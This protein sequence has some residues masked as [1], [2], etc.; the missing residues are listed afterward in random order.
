MGRVFCWWGFFLCGK[1]WDT[2]F[3]HCPRLW[4]R[5][6]QRVAGKSVGLLIQ[7]RNFLEQ[8]SVFLMWSEFKGSHLS[9]TEVSRTISS[10]FSRLWIMLLKTVLAIQL[11]APSMPQGGIP[12]S[13]CSFQI[14]CW[15]GNQ[16]VCNAFLVLSGKSL[17]IKYTLVIG[18][19]DLRFQKFGNYWSTSSLNC[20]ASGSCTSW[21]KDP[22]GGDCFFACTLQPFFMFTLTVN[23]FLC[24][25]SS[26]KYQLLCLWSC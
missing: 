22:S 4:S 23:F 19:T 21:G 24:L 16:Q 10:I 5:T 6:L 11:V 9:I 13:V 12:I 7:L 15:L 18:L 25:I 14:H 26:N 8:I 20:M 2:F 17:M 3:F 1:S